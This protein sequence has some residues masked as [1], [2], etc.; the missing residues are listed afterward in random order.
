[1]TYRIR[2]MISYWN[3]GPRTYNKQKLYGL[4]P[5]RWPMYGWGGWVG[6]GAGIHRSRFWSLNVLLCLLFLCTFWGQ[7]DDPY[8]GGSKVLSG[9]FVLCTFFLHTC[10]FWDQNDDPC[11][12]VGGIHC[13]AIFPAHRHWNLEMCLGA[14]SPC[15]KKQDM[16]ETTNRRSLGARPFLLSAW[17]GLYIYIYIYTCIYNMDVA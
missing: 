15:P 3:T 6:G 5:E 2:Q 1:M 12:G 13:S 7:N 11:I 14:V 4:G 10:T 16:G 8:M 17:A 9:P